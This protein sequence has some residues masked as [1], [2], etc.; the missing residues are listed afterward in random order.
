MTSTQQQSAQSD[1]LGMVGVLLREIRVIRQLTVYDVA[2]T[3]FIHET[4]VSRVETGGRRIQLAWYMEIC[5]ILNVHPCDVWRVAGENITVLAPLARWREELRPGHLSESLAKVLIV[6]ATSQEPEFYAAEV[7]SQT[8][9]SI[10][11]VSQLCHRLVAIGWFAEAD[12]IPT[13]RN[14]PHRYYRVT[15]KGEDAI[16]DIVPVAR[17]ARELATGIV[18]RSDMQSIGLQGHAVALPVTDS[19]PRDQNEQADEAPSDL[20]GSVSRA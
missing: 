14:P 6:L 1:P 13:D 9:L 19:P 8:E 5:Q 16:G 12:T 2:R 4:H 3:T 7:A 20:S 15:K 18:E 11:Q 17:R 10:Y